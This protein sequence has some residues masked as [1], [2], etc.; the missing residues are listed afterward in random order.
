MDKNNKA[1]SIDGLD[2]GSVTGNLSVSGH[3]SFVGG[4]LQ[5]DKL[6]I[7]NTNIGVHFSDME[8]FNSFIETPFLAIELPCG[9]KREYGD[10][11]DIPAEDVKCEHDNYFIKI[12]E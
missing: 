11:Q 7:C 10:K 4:E 12:G 5:T 1:N 2:T 3:L 8:A 6:Q 9:C